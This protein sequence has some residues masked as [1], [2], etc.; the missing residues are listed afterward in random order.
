MSTVLVDRVDAVVTLTLNRPEKRNALTVEM[1]R[2]FASELEEIAGDSHVR[3]VVIRG[4]GPSFCV[5]ADLH[6]FATN[7]ANSARRT[8]L[9]VGHRVVGLLAELPQPTIAAIHGHALGGGLELALACDLRIAT[10][11]ARL[12]LPEVGLGTIPGWGGTQ[13]LANAVG[14]VRA[15]AM[16]LLSEIVDGTSARELGLVSAACDEGELDASVLEMATALAAQ[17]A[18]AV[19]LAKQVMNA[20]NAHSHRLATYEALAGAVSVTTDDLREGI[21]AFIEKREPRFEGS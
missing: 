2:Q 5:G 11:G 1:L 12:G 18:V 3:V 16:V 9:A 8:W 10:T 19:Q 13:R 17:P 20:T 7:D 4:S 14:P 6:A 15:K 21:S